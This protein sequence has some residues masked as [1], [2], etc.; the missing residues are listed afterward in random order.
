MATARA[1]RVGPEA[2]KALVHPLRLAMW[3]H[4]GDHG[5]A[6]A[7]QLAQALG[8]SSGQTSYHLRQLERFGFVEDDPGHARGRERWWRAVG[9]T[10]LPEDLRDDTMQDE[11]RALMQSRLAARAS[12]LTRWIQGHRDEAPEWLEAST[13]AEVRTRMTAAELHAL[14]EELEQ[15]VMRHTDAVKAR[16]AQGEHRAQGATGG[17]GVQVVTGEAGARAEPVDER[18]VRVFLDAIAL[19]ADEAD[20]GR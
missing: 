12:L 5:A 20:V 10:M 3:E 16:R 19:P 18:R 15:V 2:L 7:T 6:T 8:E 9:F 14:G 1:S 11:V 4:L 17:R 13:S